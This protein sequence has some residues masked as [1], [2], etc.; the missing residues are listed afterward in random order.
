MKRCF[1]ALRVNDEAR[2]TMEAIGR[3][4][5]KLPRTAARKIRPVKPQNIHLT[6]KFLGA[7][8]DAQ[9]PDLLELLELI[10]SETTLGSSELKGLGAF[11]SLARPRIIYGK[12]ATRALDVSALAEEVE[13]L[14]EALG[15]ER[16]TRSRRPHVTIARIERA[17]PKGPLTTFLDEHTTCPLGALDTGALVLFESTLQPGGAIYTPLGEF[18]L[19][20]S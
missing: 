19:G 13:T 17:K 14:C 16:E 18:Q 7:T 8:G 4:L 11:P 12:V 5:K 20:A 3:R 10:A 1:V 15:F 2:D 6:L 9:V